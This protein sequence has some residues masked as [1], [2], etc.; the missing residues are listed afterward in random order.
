MDAVTPGLGADI[1][2]RVAH[3]GGLGIENPVLGRDTHGH[4][5]D[6]DVAVIALVEIATAADRGDADAIAVAA[7]PGDHAGDEMLGLGVVRA[8]EAKR[9]EIGDGPRAHGEDIA[10]DAADARCRALI[11]LDERGMVMALH[12]ED[13]GQPFA[14]IDDT[15]V[16]AR[17]ADHPGRFRRQAPQPFARRFIGAM[18]APH[19]RENAELG[20]VGLAPQNIDHLAVFFRAQP[21]AGDDVGWVGDIGRHQPSAS[22]SP[23]NM[24]RPSVPVRRASA[25]RSG[26]GIMPS[27]L[28]ASLVIPAILAK[29]PLGLA[30]AV[31]SPLASA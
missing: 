9:V 10:Q 26:W 25:S 13:R 5:I 20:D 15:G 24:A 30:A 23:S 6:Q 12:L 27:T 14:D 18:L 28:P 2:H 4:G 21:M 8:A 22:T 19:H 16:L 3:A 31:T 29:D 7:D 17:A 11:G 1:D